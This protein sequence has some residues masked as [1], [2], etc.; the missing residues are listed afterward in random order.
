MHW[1]QIPNI[2]FFI[3]NVYNPTSTFFQKMHPLRIFGV[4]TRK[5][6]WV[7]QKCEVNQYQKTNFTAFQT[8]L[9][10]YFFIYQSLQSEENSLRLSCQKNFSGFFTCG[11]LSLLSTLHASSKALCEMCKNLENFF[12]VEYSEAVEYS[13]VIKIFF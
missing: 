9:R 11:Q 12:S 10:S 2:Q 8:H 5:T 7:P 4:F 1:F 6:F 13:M 3:G